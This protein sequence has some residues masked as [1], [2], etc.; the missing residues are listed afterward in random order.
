MNI[1]QNIKIAV[2]AIVFGYESNVLKVLLIKQKFG[3]LK[4]QWAL[5]GG[6]VLDGESL[7]NAVYRELKEEAG[8][9]VTY[10][11]QLYTFGDV[12]R[13]PR[14]RVVSVAYFGLVNSTKLQLKADTDAE[15]ARWFPFNDLPK[16]AF[17]HEK[18]LKMAYERLKNKLMYQPIGF[19]L[20]PDEFAFS[21]LENLYST[22]I[23]ANID[24][25][26]FRKKI[27]SYQLLIETTKI[28][29][30]KSG[31]P[32]RLFKFDKQKYE[33]LSASGFY[34]EIKLA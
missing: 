31:R 26:N 15:D 4:N 18:I 22:I 17:D 14:M 19:D 27:Q 12:D 23:N 30:K 11:E 20:L 32:A 1:N 5:V 29:G 34:F 28:A 10:L 6:F 7:E 21:D 33:Q 3:E 16:M 2:D 24:R 13:D 9:S 8:I 25:R